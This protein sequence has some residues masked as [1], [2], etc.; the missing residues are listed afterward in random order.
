M[1][2]PPHDPH[3]PTSATQLRVGDVV[4]IGDPSGWWTCLQVLEL[5]PR[6]RLHW[7]Y[8]LLPWRG[9]REPTLDDVRGLPPLHR[10]M[11]GIE[12]FTQG[13]ASVIGCI[14]PADE[15]QERHYG[16]S[17]VGKSQRVTGWRACLRLARQYARTGSDDPR[18]LRED[19]D[20]R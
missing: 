13:G 16:P 14:P 10:G 17:Y 2:R 1:P 3:T 6:A 7:I 8:G 11:T 12:L 4:P 19:D 9:M 18:G 20:G 5:K 15:G